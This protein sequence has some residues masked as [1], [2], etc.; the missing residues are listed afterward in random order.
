MVDF[1]SGDNIIM[2]SMVTYHHTMQARIE[3]AIRCSRQGSSVVFVCANMPPRFWPDATDDFMC[4]ENTSWAKRNEHGELSVGNRQQTHATCLCRLIKNC[5][6]TF[7]LS[8][9]RI[10]ALRTSFGQLI[11][12]GM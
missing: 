3:G 4:K 2:Q 11:E 10:F 9:D 1:C 5:S 6:H 12:S 8:C 7:W